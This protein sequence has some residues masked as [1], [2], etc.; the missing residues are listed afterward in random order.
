M[1]EESGWKDQLRKDCIQ[2]AKDHPSTEKGTSNEK[3]PEDAANSAH[4]TAPDISLEAMINALVSKSKGTPKSNFFI[5]LKE[6]KTTV[7]TI[8][9]CIVLPC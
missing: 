5:H 6:L 7:T 3:K 8:R 1:L 9:S 4:K 2:Y